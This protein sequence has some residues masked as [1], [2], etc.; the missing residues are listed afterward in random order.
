[1]KRE[2]KRK[3]KIKRNLTGPFWAK[4]EFATQFTSSPH[5]PLDHCHCN[6][7]PT[8][9]PQ[10]S[11]T[12]NGHAPS[13][14]Y[15]VGLGQTDVSSRAAHLTSSLPLSGGVRLSGLSPPLQRSSEFCSGS[16]FRSAG[17]PGE[18]VPGVGFGR[19]Y[20]YLLRLSLASLYPCARPEPYH[21]R[22]IFL[23][24][25][26]RRRAR[27]SIRHRRKS[28]GGRGSTPSGRVTIHGVC[29]SNHRS[30]AP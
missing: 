19:A 30:R 9:G 17:N 7:T 20:I 3:I 15:H 10:S 14:R 29:M 1:L 13:S 2:R 11:M 22:A 8:C 28:L 5:G 12:H 23:G 4:T 24:K 27:P 6:P 21:Q 18:F 25:G 16:T 26:L